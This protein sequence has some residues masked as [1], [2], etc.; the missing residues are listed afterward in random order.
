MNDTLKVTRNPHDIAERMDISV[1]KARA[2]LRKC[3]DDL[4]GWGPNRKQPHII[5]RR[6][7][8]LDW[9]S[10]DGLRLAHFRKLHD[11][12]SVNMCQGRDGSFFILYAFPNTKMVKRET[13]FYTTKG[14]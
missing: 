11:Q 9:P 8:N 10:K 14:Y 5:S 12:G 3:Q 13:Y 7:V 1:E 2:M 6:H 4:A